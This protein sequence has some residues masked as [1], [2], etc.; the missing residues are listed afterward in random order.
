MT[1]EGFLSIEQIRQLWPDEWVLIGNPIIEN[2]H[3][4]GGVPVF[5]AKEK[6]GL[7]EGKDLLEGFDLKTWV[8][9]GDFPKGRKFWLGIY[10][11]IPE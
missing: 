10:R 4:L 11:Q 6:K 2:T 8:Y 3:V 9:T 5:H 1:A 7:L